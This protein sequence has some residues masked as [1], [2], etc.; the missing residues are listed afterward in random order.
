MTFDSVRVQSV[1][2]KWLIVVVKLSCHVDGCVSEFLYMLCPFAA[3]QMGTESWTRL[4]SVWSRLPLPAPIHCWLLSD[5]CFPLSLLTSGPLPTLGA[6]SA[7]HRPEHCV[8]V[9]LPN[10]VFTVRLSVCTDLYH[11][12]SYSRSALKM[13]LKTNLIL[14]FVNGLCLNYGSYIWLQANNRQIYINRHWLIIG[15]HSLKC[16][17]NVLM[18]ISSE[19]LGKI[20]QRYSNHITLKSTF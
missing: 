8:S 14:F 10:S 6:V 18:S 19:Y 17:C 2:S 20:L 11:H 5:C 12:T 3:E 9:R 7:K 16:Q 15:S 4:C 1:G 13:Q